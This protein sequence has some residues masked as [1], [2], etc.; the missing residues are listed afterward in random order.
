MVIDLR[1]LGVFAAII[2]SALAPFALAE[3]LHDAAQS[4]DV[5]E[6]ERLIDQGADIGST[7][8]RQNLTPLFLAAAHGHMA[9][10]ERLIANGAEVD[11]RMPPTG[12]TPLWGAAV[13]RHLAVVDLLIQKGANVNAMSGK[14]E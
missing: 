12:M 2:S 1:L 4:G 5:A 3:P 6:V 11:V 8:H 13:K 14:D 7:N 9:V 10:V